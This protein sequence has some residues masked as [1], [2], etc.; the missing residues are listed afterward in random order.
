MNK[1]DLNT[2]LSQVINIFGDSMAQGAG[3]LNGMNLNG[4]L[5][6]FLPTRRVIKTYGIGGQNSTE[7]AARFG[8]IPTKI[9]IT[10]GV[11]PATGVL[12]G[13][14]NISPGILST[15]DGTSRVLG[16]T[17]LTNQGSVVTKQPCY[18]KRVASNVYTFA[19][20]SGYF[21]SGASVPSN[22]IF[23]PEF[24]N[25][26]SD[27][28]NIFWMGRNDAGTAYLTTTFNNV[29]ACVDVLKSPKRFLAIGILPN[30]DE[31]NGQTNRLRINTYNDLIKSTYPNNFI[32]TTPPTSE[33]MAFINYTPTT[34]DLADIANG[35]FPRGMKPEGD[36]THLTSSGYA[37]MAY[38]V[39]KLFKAYQW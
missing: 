32:E 1:N 39:S 7:I 18:I 3:S 23:I 4:N 27:D 38:R 16:G 30:S 8:A 33:E 11:L 15:A 34:D 9:T 2:G 14:D 29:K 31:V 28:I 20:I 26:C 36:I 10:G 5:L 12:I 19:Y 37:I 24:L 35:I 6:S 22:M 21:A 17:I 13:L 25:N